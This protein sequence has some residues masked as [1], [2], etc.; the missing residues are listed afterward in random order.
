MKSLSSSRLGLG[1]W[2]RAVACGSILFGGASL[3]EAQAR[4]G[5]SLGQFEQRLY[6]DG[7]GTRYTRHFLQAKLDDDVPPIQMREYFPQPHEIRVYFKKDH[8]SEAN[9]QDLDDGENP[10]GWDIY[11]VY[12][13]G[14]SV[15]ETYKRNGAALSVHELNGLLHVQRGDSLWLRRE[16][17]D[18]INSELGYDYLRQD[19]KIRAV[20]DGRTLTFYLV[21]LDESILRQ[22]NDERAEAEAEARESAPASVTGF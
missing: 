7:G 16:D 11:V 14:R 19:G 2:V 6:I 8:R 20:R 22:R 18:T 3:P 17:D 10:P 13:G 21:E 12:V 5:D 1:P 4:I 9:S 15:M